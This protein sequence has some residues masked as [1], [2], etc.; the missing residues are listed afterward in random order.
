M[1]MSR[2]TMTLHSCIRTALS[3]SSRKITR[4]KTPTASPFASPTAT[5]RN[6]RAVRLLVRN[7]LHLATSRLPGLSSWGPLSGSCHGAITA[8][9][10]LAL[11]RVTGHEPATPLD[12]CRRT[13]KDGRP[14]QEGG[15][16][17]GEERIGAGGGESL[18]G[19]LPNAAMDWDWRKAIRNHF[20]SHV[21]L[22]CGRRPMEAARSLGME[23]H[24]GMSRREV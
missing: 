22:G 16:A 14:A 2:V 18:D 7:A 10:S 24:V 6:P 4:S 11:D 17:K 3:N 8:H 13:D 5:P 19:G 21:E 15:V 12:G 1:T 9:H 23:K 20:E